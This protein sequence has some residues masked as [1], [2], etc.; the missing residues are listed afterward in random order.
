MCV[1]GRE[2]MRRRLEGEEENDGGAYSVEV[3]L[4]L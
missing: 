1:G 4:D 2:V 3:R